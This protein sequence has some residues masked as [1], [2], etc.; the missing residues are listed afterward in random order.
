[1]EATWESP[2]GKERAELTGETEA[3]LLAQA[4]KLDRTWVAKQKS[5]FNPQQSSLRDKARAFAQGGTLG[6]QDELQALIGAGLTSAFDPNSTDS[7]METYENLRED[8]RTAQDIYSA[9]HP[10]EN[11]ALQMAGGLAV[12][13]GAAMRGAQGANRWGQLA[14]Q[15]AVMGGL[16]GLGTAEGGPLT[17]AISTAAG[18]GIGAGLGLAAPVAT[19][20]IGN[21]GRAGAAALANTGRSMGNRAQAALGMR[22][23]PGPTRAQR[24]DEYAAGMLNEGTGP[25][26]PERERL[27]NRARELGM[28]LT[29]GERTDHTAM[30]QFE[31]AQRSNPASP[32]GWR[33]NEARTNNRRVVNNLTLRAIGADEVGEVSEPIVARRARELNRIFDAI[34]RQLGTMRIDNQ[35]RREL[36]QMMTAVS[37]PRNPNRKAM[38]TIRR[39]QES[40]D[41]NQPMTGQELKRYRSDFANDAKKAWINGDANMGEF[42][43]GMVDMLEGIVDRQVVRRSGRFT[44]AQN[45]PRI[46][47]D[48]RRQWK[49]VKALQQGNTMRH[50]DV[51]YGNMANAL[52]KADR[53]GFRDMGVIG[54]GTAESDLYDALRMQQYFGDIVGDSGTATR[55]AYNALE[56]QSLPRMVGRAAARGVMAPI[57]GGYMRYGAGGMLSPNQ[58]GQGAMGP[59]TAGM[60]GYRSVYGGMFGED[61]PEEEE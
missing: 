8:E 7:F 47:A 17:Q 29:P 25:L 41:F 48:A 52:Q 44:S 33:L 22:V 38:A 19:Q 31:A 15:G 2:D 11:F 16:A 55:T 39:F 10:Q 23:T 1:M 36:N 4:A 42:Y 35:A 40:Q 59:L 30:R 21:L 37:N 50:G 3:Q 46:W 49:I 58:I 51:L 34:E 26:G 56:Q 5:V 57:G 60:S 45:V 61:Q 20:A 28:E 53:R 27:V 54:R 32:V 9:R 6:F 43:N 13:G 18:T 12:P 24:M 14:R